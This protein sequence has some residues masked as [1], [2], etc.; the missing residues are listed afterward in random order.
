MAQPHLWEGDQG[1]SGLGGPR[2]TSYPRERVVSF[3]GLILCLLGGQAPLGW[4]RELLSLCALPRPHELLDPGVGA[5]V[6]A[7]PTRSL[8]RPQHHLVQSDPVP[9]AAEE[10]RGQGVADE[11]VALGGTRALGE[12]GDQRSRYQRLQLHTGEGG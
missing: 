3:L 2:P 4:K 9:G 12:Q 10:V 1:V 11:Q 7:W 6:G 8:P 5:G